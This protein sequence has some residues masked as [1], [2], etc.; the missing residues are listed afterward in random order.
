MYPCPDFAVEPQPGDTIVIVGAMMTGKTTMAQE[1]ALRLLNK[2]LSV[3]VFDD[4]TRNRSFKKG[5]ARGLQPVKIVVLNGS[6]NLFDWIYQFVIQTRPNVPPRRYSVRPDKR[7]MALLEALRNYDTYQFAHTE[8]ET[9]RGLEL[10][11]R[12]LLRHELNLHT[13]K[14]RGYGKQAVVTFKTAFRITDA[15]R[16]RLASAQESKSQDV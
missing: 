8:A 5:I 4:W 6:F 3:L 11:D 7:D 14:E 15:G 2:G 9:R 10:A 1:L 16:V 12:G 13:R